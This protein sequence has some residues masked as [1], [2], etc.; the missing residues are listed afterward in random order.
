LSW[1]KNSIGVEPKRAEAFGRRF[2][3]YLQ[4]NDKD[5]NFMYYCG[6][7]MDNESLFDT[8]KFMQ[9]TNSISGEFI[10][11][12]GMKFRTDKEILDLLIGLQNN[13]IKTID[14]TFFGDEEYH[15]RFA[16]RK[17]DYNYLLSI[18]NVSKETNLEVIASIPIYKDNIQQLDKLIKVLH[19]KK[20]NKIF[21]RVPN[22]KGRGSLL[23]D[24]RID[25]HDYNLLTDNVKKYLNRNIYQTE[26]EIIRDSK[27]LDMKYRSLTLALT[28]SNIDK[29]E[30]LNIRDIIKYLEQL[31][32]SYYAVIPSLIEL[33]K[34]YS[35][36]TSTKLYS[37]KQLYY[38][39]QK[40]Y[41]KENELD[42]YDI[43]DETHSFS[44]RY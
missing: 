22:D 36:I 18:L 41:I 12:N 2:Y 16:G 15:D 5:I 25:I 43:N 20:V 8:I 1:V 17:G 35:H 3:D 28:K 39:Y 26:E 37:K 4:E 27:G 29:L 42:I 24:L 23:S 11:L 38:K 34:K 40:Q 14:L 13:G 21:I 31:D 19:V 30:A 10:Q 7:S 44:V 33:I 32:D 6:Y 9:E